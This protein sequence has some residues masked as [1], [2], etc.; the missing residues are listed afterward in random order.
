MSFLDEPLLLIPIHVDALAVGNQ[1]SLPPKSMFQWTNLTPNFSKLQTEYQFA[2]QLIG[3]PGTGGSPF[4]A[5]SGLETGIHLHFRL[6]RAFSRGHQQGEGP[7]SFPAI[8]NRW[9]VQR[10]G[11]DRAA[12]TAWLIKS[13]APANDA[14]ATPWPKFPDDEQTPAEFRLI[15]TYT[16]V[17]AS[18]GQDDEPANVKLTAMGQGNPLF[19]AHYPACRTVL[20][21]HDPLTEV[22]SGA[23][24]TYL[25][26][27]WFSTAA[28]D[29]L[30][31][32]VWR[33]GTIS[34]QAE[35]DFRAQNK[36]PE[37]VPLT[38]DQQTKLLW[39]AWARERQ[40]ACE[41]DRAA[42]A[43]SRLLCHGLVR[44]I[45]WHGGDWNY[46]QPS[47]KGDSLSQ[48]EV[49][50]RNE[51]NHEQAYQVAVGNT[52]GEAL[53]AL[54]AKGNVDQDLLAALHDGLLGQ[55]VTAAELQYELHSRRFDAI[56]GGT[57]FAIQPEPDYSELKDAQAVNQSSRG[58][59]TILP[60]PL[61]DLLRRLNEK[62]RECDRLARKVADCRWQVYALWY[63]WTSELKRGEDS[64]R[65]T[66]LRSQLD[67]FKVVLK[68]TR[69]ALDTAI[70]ERDELC[71]ARPAPEPST[72]KIIEELAKYPRTQPDGSLRLNA[73]KPELKFRLVVSTAPPFYE[74]SEPVIAVAGPATARLNTADPSSRALLCRFSSQ[75]VNGILLQVPGGQNVTVQAEKFLNEVFPDEP[76]LQL[77]GGANRA[78][79]AEALLLD[80]QQASNIADHA[81]PQHRDELTKIVKALQDP[82][83]TEAQRNPPPP[84][85]ALL[86]RRPDPIAIFSWQR[87]PWIPLLLAW[88]VSWQSDYEAR[89]GQPVPEDL[90]SSGWHLD[91]MSGDL[92]RDRAAPTGNKA[93]YK[94]YSILTASVSK[95]LAESLEKLNPSHPLIDKLK[96]QNA[97]LQRLAGFND[98]LIR[99]QVVMQIPPLDYQRW[100]DSAD[101]STYFVDSIRDFLNEDFARSKGPNSFR[102]V[103]DTGGNP[104]MP[105]RAGQ[106]EITK[107]SIVD[108][109]GQTLIL[110]V[111]RI[112]ESASTPTSMLHRAHSLLDG[113]PSSPGSAIPLKPR[114]VQPTRLQF[115][116]LNA[117]RNVSGNG[118]PLSGWVLPN[119]LEK[120][121]TIY[122]SN[123]KLLGA[124]QRKL[125]QTSGSEDK[126]AFYWVDVP[127]AQ[128]G[129]ASTMDVKERLPKI[130]ENTHLLYFCSWVLN[131][132][133]DMGATFSSVL[134]DAIA[135]ADQRVP[136]E[137]PG[138]SMLVG[139]PLALMRADL[140]LEIA[141]LPSRQP[142][143][144]ADTGTNVRD[145]IETKEFEKVKWALRLGNFNARNDGLIGVFKC[146]A[147]VPQNDALTTGP[148]YASWGRDKELFQDN[149]KVFAVQDFSIDCIQPLAVTM[150]MDPQARVHATTGVLPRGFFELPHETQAGAKRARE[151]VFQTAP[152]LGFTPTPAMPRPSDDYGEWSWAYRPD[153][154]HWK[155]DPN[156]IEA[157]DRG[158]FNG[159]WPTIAE[160]W[161]KLAIAPV[162][163]LSFWLREP[164]ETVPAR[165]RVHLA[166]SLQGAESLEL[167]KVKED[168]KTIEPVERWDAQPFPS[169]YGVMVDAK[170]TYRL[171]AYAEDGK[172]DTKDLTIKVAAA[173]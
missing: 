140:Q 58:R 129:D 73:G 29:P 27:G 111:T 48:P 134:N 128:N 125:G 83:S 94:G 8:P 102:T 162:K 46:M 148:F 118:G 5:A 7:L 147:A 138:V 39:N 35:R 89:A 62:Q 121:L 171:I 163:V 55:P 24:L 66:K 11:G 9:L 95:N 107:L 155:L 76:L 32:S 12:Y 149:V 63:V 103:P 156:L 51:E 100:F 137:D 92:V 126:A 116:S 157:T 154:T 3:D 150:L 105:I 144:R 158:G 113:K 169:E 79:L 153:V 22:S 164:T 96:N 50:P 37:G 78:L 52:G 93:T 117:A 59:A 87:N 6:T 168:G 124:L 159:A 139:R 120:S 165:T 104:F 123:G 114:F 115:Q 49:F 160:G 75:L 135:S 90:V 72:G 40:W 69:A 54:L 132:N 70:A 127:G 130:I 106:L 56:Q 31:T 82:D 16:E 33:T 30:H 81:S 4:D 119:Y 64:D 151:V 74:P 41:L 84:P 112:N 101:T 36:I 15:G 43:P 60:G 85:N 136:D 172:S 143:L 2:S 53:A 99:Q 80:E 152:V 17:T 19:S 77:L 98:A 67:T 28:D 26:T 21:F 18:V 57:T 88:E 108:V 122:D 131:L 45:T 133:P 142:E 86:G 14:W 44:G 1:G 97:Q 61:A 167:V 109:F 68:N 23:R 13:D 20:G 91:S 25:I 166:W 170:T 110:P 145:L 65:I 34:P 173:H 146:S 47:D 38:P 71:T 42:E 141:G 161:L 10:F